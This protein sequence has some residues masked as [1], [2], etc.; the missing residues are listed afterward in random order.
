MKYTPTL[1]C[2]VL[3]SSCATI[4]NQSENTLIT[5]NPSGANLTITDKNKTL[6][7][8]G[9]SPATVQLKASDG[10]F[11][12]ASYNVCI[13]KKGL[14]TRNIELRSELSGWYFGNILLGGL[15]GMVIVDPATGKMWKMPED[16]NVELTAIA[17]IEDGNGRKLAIVDHSSL[18]A[19]D[20]RL[21]TPVSATL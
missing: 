12:S 14:P 16:Y 2:A 19:T 21:L 9:V 1:L 11:K 18:P 10:Y 20:R 17:S 6:V 15:I 13:T 3:L 8:K 4:F 7:F 5:T